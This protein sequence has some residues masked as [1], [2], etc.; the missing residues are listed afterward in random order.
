MTE[1]HPDPLLPR[2][3]AVVWFLALLFFAAGLVVGGVIGGDAAATG[4][5]TLSLAAVLLGITGQ[6]LLYA[7]RGYDALDRLQR[8]ATTSIALAS[9][10]ATGGIVAL[11]VFGPDRPI[12]PVTAVA[13]AAVMAAAASAAA[14][15]SVL[16]RPHVEAMP[17]HIWAGIGGSGLAVPFMVAGVDPALIVAATVGLATYDR[18][19]GRRIHRDL[20]RRRALSASIDERGIP[21]RG[22]PGSPVI[23]RTRPRVPW[24]RR[25][26]RLSLALGVAALLTVVGA[27]AGGV[28]IAD[29]APGLVSAGQGLAVVTLGAI[30]LVAQVALLL[31]VATRARRVI[32]TTGA[33]IVAASAAVLITPSESVALVAWAVQ[34][35]AVGLA[36]S[37]VTRMLVPGTALG[38][39]AI[40][41]TVATAWWVVVVTSGGIALA[42]GAVLT[43]LLALR[44]R[45]TDGDLPPAEGAA[46]APPA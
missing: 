16:I 21:V 2:P 3:V 22:L 24:S 23:E 14:A 27:W 43:T 8:V 39:A 30:P 11:I 1:A 10:L 19:R 9:A 37:A 5:S 29:A 35:V 34:S 20:E 15:T 41:V 45:T 38:A 26:R 33:V 6:G 13:A 12:G 31:R 46:P 42:F 18:V 28:L 36:V 32:A 17:A 7:R 40:V 44:R 4:T 25:E